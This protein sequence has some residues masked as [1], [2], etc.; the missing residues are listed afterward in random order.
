MPGGSRSNRRDAGM[1]QPSSID[2]PSTGSSVSSKTTVIP[3][4]TRR[5]AVELTRMVESVPDNPSSLHPGEFVLASTYEVITLPD[6]IA[7]RLEEV[8]AGPART[9][10]PLNSPDSS[11]PASPGT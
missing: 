1:V 7:G 3:S 2:M 5:R 8:V 4:S 11:T 6:D 9:A 10:D